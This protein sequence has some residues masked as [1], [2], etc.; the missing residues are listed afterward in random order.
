MQTYALQVRRVTA[1][2]S[3]AIQIE[4]AP[5]AGCDTMRAFQPGQ[6]LTLESGPAADMQWRCYSIFT[7]PETDG[8]ICLLVRRVK[9]GLVSNWLC[10]HLKAGDTLK[11][12]PPAGR[13]IL[14]RADAE[15]IS[16]FAGGSGIAPI[17]ALCRQALEQG[18]R[19]VQLFY[20]NR[21][22]ASSMLNSA[23][24]HLKTQYPEQLRVHY[25]YDDE[26]GLPCATDFFPQV[27]ASDVYICGPTPFMETVAQAAIAAGIPDEHIYLES[28]AT[29]DTPAE[30]SSDGAQTPLQVQLKGKTHD[31]LVNSQETLL[32]AMIRA[33]LP[34]PHACKVGECASCMCRLHSGNVERLENDVLDEDDEA[35]G[36]ILA[37]RTRPCGDA[38]EIRFP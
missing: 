13:F 10:E 23:L 17:Y 4:L 26:R 15:Q 14:R 12:L 33:G 38:I 32:A 22:Q 27:G 16:L 35:D 19:N 5:E 24:E 34:A 28:F 25:W 37:C 21:S 2:G 8:A 11:T 3:D 1:Q 20:A 7:L 36:W 9:D 31:L 18:A 6:Y 29:D 30:S